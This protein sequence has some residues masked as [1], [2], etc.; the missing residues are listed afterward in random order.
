MS[1]TRISRAGFT[2][3]LLNS[4]RPS[5]HAR[6]AI[7]R[8]LKKRAAQSHLSMRMPVI[9]KLSV[10]GCQLLEYRFSRSR[11]QIVVNP[12]NLS[13]FVQLIHSTA[14]IKFPEVSSGSARNCYSGSRGQFA[15]NR[16]T[17]DHH[18][19]AIGSFF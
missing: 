9:N 15:K 14:E 3:C 2:G 16:L 8:V 10:A 1:P 5:S 11:R 4:M 7:A 17:I 13:E 6:A 12:P 19:L 18:Q